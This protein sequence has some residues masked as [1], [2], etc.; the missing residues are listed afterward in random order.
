MGEGSHGPAVL[1]VINKQIQPE[2][3][4]G[5]NQED[6]ELDVGDRE[7]REVIVNHREGS[8]KTDIVR[9]KEG[10]EA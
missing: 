7:K 6:E 1:G 3:G 8:W 5:G 4:N 2:E 10:F 9:G